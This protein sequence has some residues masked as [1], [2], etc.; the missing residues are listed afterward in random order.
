MLAFCVPHFSSKQ[1]IMLRSW[2]LEKLRGNHRCLGIYPVCVKHNTSL[3]LGWE[4]K[5]RFPMLAFQLKQN[6]M[7]SSWEVARKSS[8]LGIYSVRV[9]HNTSLWLGW[10]LKKPFSHVGILGRKF[11]SSHFEEVWNL[12]RVD[13][14]RLKHLCKGP[15]GW[16]RRVSLSKDTFGPVKR[17]HVA[18]DRCT[19]TMLQP[20]SY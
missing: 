20:N 8:L 6:L 4:L 1:N 17:F 3:W 14:I 12:H 2:A 7:L 19:R 15:A 11:F 9:N 10:K 13:M 18:Q 16:G 5:N